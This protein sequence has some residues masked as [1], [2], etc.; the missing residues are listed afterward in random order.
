MR[1]SPAGERGSSVRRAL[2]QSDAPWSQY[3]L[4]VRWSAG[5]LLVYDVSLLIMLTVLLLGRLYDWFGLDTLP[6]PIGG[7][8]PL[9]V[10]WAGA[11]GGLGISFVG[12]VRHVGDWGPRV[13]KAKRAADHPGFA[14]RLDWN[15]WHVTRPFVG[16]IFGSVAALAVVFI[17]GSVGATAEGGLDLSPLGRATLFVVAFVVGYRD[18]TFRELADRVIDTVFGPGTPS[19]ATA[20]YDLSPTTVDFGDVAVNQTK[21]ATVTITNTGSRLLRMGT[22]TVTGTGL[23]PV[24]TTANLGA[25]QSGTITLRFEPTATGALEGSLVVKAGDVEK[26]VKV[27]GNAV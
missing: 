23:R 18:R 14:Q 21:D 17:F 15:A 2:E 26:I 13:E 11:L 7:M 19:D 25:E 3:P 22:P 5:G 6:D 8:V 16:A 20:S 1:H 24:G 4:V 27:T 12:L 10:P 9:V